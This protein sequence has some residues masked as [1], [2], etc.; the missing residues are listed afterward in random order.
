MAPETEPEKNSDPIQ[1][2]TGI[3][4]VFLEIYLR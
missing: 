1:F 3:S 2:Q 4:K